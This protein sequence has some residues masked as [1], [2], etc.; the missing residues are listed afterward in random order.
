LTEFTADFPPS[1]LVEHGDRVGAVDEYQS[2]ILSAV[3]S[4]VSHRDRGAVRPA[5]EDR[6]FE[7]GRVDDPS[8]AGGPPASSTA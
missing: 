8:R 6:A 2:A 5:D 3:L 4:G 7:L 1:G